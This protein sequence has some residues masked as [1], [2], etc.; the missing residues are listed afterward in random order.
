MSSTT[1]PEPASN[2]DV[3]WTEK[4]DQI[5]A[6]VMEKI[7]KDPDFDEKE[8]A[9]LREMISAWNGWKSLGRL[10]KWAVYVLAG[11][12]AAITTYNSALVALKEWVA[13]Q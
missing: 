3:G 8:A 5:L 4:H 6:K 11:V 1:P 12:A 9:M 7:R 2:N 10:A 13:N